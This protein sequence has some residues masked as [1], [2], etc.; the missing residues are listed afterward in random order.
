MYLKTDYYL[1]EYR[2][3]YKS[4]KEV[5]EF[6]KKAFPG[7]HEIEIQGSHTLYVYSF[8]S[9]ALYPF[10]LNALASNLGSFIGSSLQRGKVSRYVAKDLLR[11]YAFIKGK[12]DMD[13]RNAYYLPPSR[14]D[15][16]SSTLPSCLKSSL[17]LRRCG[18]KVPGHDY[19]VGISILQLMLLGKPFDVIKE[20]N[21]AATERKSRGS[22]CVDAQIHF[23]GTDYEVFME[24]DMG[25]E[26]YF[27]L[28]SKLYLYKKHGLTRGRNCVL[29][30]SHELMPYS[31][32]V[33]FNK[34]EMEKLYQALREE[35]A[36]SLREYEELYLEDASE[37]VR[38][39]FTK[40]AVRVNYYI[41]LT[42]R[43]ERVD[44]KDIDDNCKV[45]RNTRD[46][47]FTIEEL[48][49]YIDELTEGTNPYRQRIYN[50]EQL[51]R[52]LHKFRG[53]SKYI[54]DLIHDGMFDPKEV[55]AV[56]N[57]GLSCLVYPS[58]LL[59]RSYDYM[60]Y[61][62]RDMIENVLE[63]YYGDLSGAEYTSLSPFIEM[64]GDIPHCILHNCYR[65]ENGS[66]LCVEH[67]GYD[68]GALCRFYYLYLYCEHI[69]V[70]LHLVGLVENNDEMLYL[71]ELSGFHTSSTVVGNEPFFLSFLNLRDPKRHLCTVH[72]TEKHGYRVMHL[73]TP[74]EIEELKKQM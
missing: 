20:V 25:T 35:E 23:Y 13:S 74:A 43:N 69:N 21:Y 51:K 45:I 62:M 1:S 6:I 36:R 26:S 60:E 12:C 11:N 22:L 27:E 44:A 40:F 71:S 68:V 47:D 24:Q 8:F 18:G 2:K 61:R 34:K 49:R 5:V 67:I 9:Y 73:S 33:T 30:S 10:G 46:M 7:V 55:M 53:M 59:S 58:V 38:R 56:L 15:E 4:D 39:L 31:S 54:C 37:D 17:K 28:V 41:A 14:C 72:K 52:S 70:P 65:M 66:L 16:I 64:D 63:K 29:F 42:E 3:D 50:I 32:C 19:G 57:D 48:R